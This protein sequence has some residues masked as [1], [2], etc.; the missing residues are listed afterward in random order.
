[1]RHQR[2]PHTCGRLDTRLQVSLLS[3]ARARTHVTCI[4][5]H[6]VADNRCAVDTNLLAISRTYYVRNISHAWHNINFFYPII[7]V[8]F[9]ITVYFITTLVVLKIHCFTPDQHKDIYMILIMY[10]FDISSCVTSIDVKGNP[11]SK[12]QKKPWFQISLRKK[13]FH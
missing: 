2:V 9:N 5:A 11:N 13:I 7:V 6:G 1:M 3:G 4:S 8:R 10:N 12:R